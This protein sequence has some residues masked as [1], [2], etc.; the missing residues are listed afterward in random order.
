MQEFTWDG[1][2]VWDFTYF[3]EKSIPHHDYTKLPNG[4]VILIM[5]ERKSPEEAIAAGRVPAT[6]TGGDM[7]LDAL[8][9]IKPTG[10]TT[11]EVVWEW[12]MWDHTIQDYDPTKPTSAMW[13][14]IRSW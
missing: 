7:S 10:K 8:V 1:E 11:G 14:P 6:V 3:T 4:N 2:L 12:H 5:I 9:E 13:P